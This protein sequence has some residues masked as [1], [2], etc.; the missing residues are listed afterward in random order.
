[1]EKRIKVIVIGG[2]T[3]MGKSETAIKVAQ[4]ISGEIISADSVQVFRYFDIGSG[5]PDAETRN[6][7]P[8][9]LIDC[10]EPDKPFSLWDFKEAARKKISEIAGR[11]N[12]P[13]LTGGTGLYIQAT[14]E[15]LDGGTQADPEL[16]A[17]LRYNIENL[18]TD[19]LY[20]WLIRLDP[21]R[22]AK[23][24]PNDTHRIIRGIE[25]ALLPKQQSSANSNRYLYDA[26]IYLLC[27]PREKIYERI[28]RQVL[29]MLDRGWIKETADILATGFSQDCKP[30][31]SVG[32]KQIVE[33]L[34]SGNG[35]M[36]TLIEEIRKQTRRYA[37]RQ[38]TWFNSVK[39]AIYINSASGNLTTDDVADFITERFKRQ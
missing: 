7:A 8:H 26:S 11:G 16:R 21:G 24:H 12:V 38:I 9:H 3:S 29:N 18:G 19:I 30:F 35:D 37:K 10:L 20:K 2:P 6:L 31:Q 13:I 14:L 28:N 22:S 36:D 33:F 15:D 17:S 32:Y 1:M 39:E 34:E 25:N 23:I 4:R 5:K 27:G